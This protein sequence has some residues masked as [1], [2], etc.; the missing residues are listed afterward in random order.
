[1]PC[2][3]MAQVA[4]LRA[5]ARVNRVNTTHFL[6]VDLGMWR[7]SHGFERWPDAARLQAWP[8]ERVLALE[9]CP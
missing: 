3:P 6:W 8:T 4:L 9:V 2:M 5:A 7:V 1:M